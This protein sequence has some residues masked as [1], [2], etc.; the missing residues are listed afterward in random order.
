MKELTRVLELLRSFATVLE[1]AG[2][3]DKL[4]FFEGKNF[5]LGA[6]RYVVNYNSKLGS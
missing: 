6:S 3:R 5:K 4:I 2:L 1:T